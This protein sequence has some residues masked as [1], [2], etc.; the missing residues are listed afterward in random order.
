MAPLVV[1]I[2]VNCCCTHVLL[3]ET[4]ETNGFFVTLLS[5]V[6]FQLGGVGVGLLVYPW[7]CLWEICFPIIL[8]AEA[9]P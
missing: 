4:E 5:L 1:N 8:A 7:L 2:I 9:T 6:A 3:K